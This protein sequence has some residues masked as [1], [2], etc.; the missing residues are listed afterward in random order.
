MGAFAPFDAPLHVIPG[1][2]QG[3]RFGGKRI[4]VK[5]FFNAPMLIKKLEDQ[6]RKLL[7]LFG[8]AVRTI[9]RRS[10]KKASGPDDYSAP[11]TPPKYHTGF[12][13]NAVAYQYTDSI[14]GVTIG[15]T[16]GNTVADLHEFGGTF[17]PRVK[18][19]GRGWDFRVGG[20]G[21]IAIDKSSLKPIVIVLRSSAQ[22]AR[23]LQVSEEYGNI[24]Y[25]AA[26][27]AAGGRRRYPARPWLQPAFEIAKRDTLPKLFEAV[28]NKGQ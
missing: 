25:R 28:Y 12:L 15:V 7:M 20:Y 27:H 9:V 1:T 23:S 6:E 14:H 26:V 21:P 3:V 22:V 8:A 19:R 16:K 5:S 11:S 24:S 18:R 4:N 2:L 13:R 17:I 10:M